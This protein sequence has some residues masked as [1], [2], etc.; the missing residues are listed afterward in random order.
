M[1]HICFYDMRTIESAE[2][3]MI[4]RLCFKLCAQSHLLRE[5]YKNLVAIS[6]AFQRAKGGHHD[7][8]LSSTRT[9]NSITKIRPTHVL[10]T[11]LKVRNDRRFAIRASYNMD[12][13]S[14]SAFVAQ[15]IL[16]IASL[17]F[18]RLLTLQQK[19]IDT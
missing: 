14:E 11:F 8:T 13:S 17:L 3:T 18:Y 19:M 15:I 4:A 5:T 1:N 7:C 2:V 12:Q 9:N 10:L 16:S 6:D